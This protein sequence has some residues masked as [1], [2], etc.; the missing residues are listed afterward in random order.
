MGAAELSE[1]GA[2]AGEEAARG[3]G[4][5]CSPEGEEVAACA[6]GGAAEKAKAKPPAGLGALLGGGAA[7]RPPPKLSWQEL[8][9]RRAENL[10]R[11]ESENKTERASFQGNDTKQHRCGNYA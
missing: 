3:K 4:P 8:E 9:Q 6:E 5:E 7:R 10:A 1:V 2:K 11:K